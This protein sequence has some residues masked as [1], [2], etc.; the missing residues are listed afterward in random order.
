MVQRTKIA[1][2]TFLLLILCL[3]AFIAYSPAADNLSAQGKVL[4]GEELTKEQFKAL[5]DSAV[6]EFKGQQKTKGQII[7]EV[8]QK[9]KQ[10]L[11]KMKNV[12]KSQFEVTRAKFLQE[13]KAKIEAANAKAKADFERLKANSAKYAAIK[14]EALQLFNK[15][16]TATPAE[17]EQIEKRANEL[18]QQL[19]QMGY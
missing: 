5:P 2:I 1:N 15:S 10:T 18:L 17:Q 14:Q 16:K 11:A 6:I 8:E 19:K 7:A 4:K 12:S 13:Q 3:A 9:R